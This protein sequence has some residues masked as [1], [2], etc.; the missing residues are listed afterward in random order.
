MIISHWI[1]LQALCAQLFSGSVVANPAGR[2]FISLL[3]DRVSFGILLNSCCLLIS[4]G[5]CHRLI[6]MLALAL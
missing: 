6:N 1:S 4:P 3:E 2:K 5:F